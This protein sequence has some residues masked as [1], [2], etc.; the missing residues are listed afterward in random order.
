MKH[1]IEQFNR[2]EESEIKRIKAKQRELDEE[3]NNFKMR[4]NSTS[5]ILK[6]K[7]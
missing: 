1:K 3:M 4:K 5:N 6:K 2:E 7:K